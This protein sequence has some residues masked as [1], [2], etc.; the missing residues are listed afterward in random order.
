MKKKFSTILVSVLLICAMVL[1]A[2]AAQ[3]IDRTSKV[4]YAECGPI[5]VETTLTVYESGARSNS[6]RANVTNTYKNNGKVIAEVTLSAT[7]GY[8]GKTAWVISASGSHT[9]YDGWSY[10]SEK[11]SKSGGTATLSATLSHSRYRSVTT[12]F[13]LTCSPT[14]Q[15]S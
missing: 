2:S 6:R 4:F 7:F 8:D 10:S 15:I 11:I 12:S 14:G 13:S 5:E 9:T 1:P 3:Q